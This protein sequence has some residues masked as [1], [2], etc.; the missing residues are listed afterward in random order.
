MGNLQSIC[1]AKLERGSAGAMRVVV[2]DP[3]P[4]IR[5]ILHETIGEWPEFLLVDESRTWKECKALLDIYLS[6]LLIV[7]TGTA[8]PNISL[9]T[10]DALFPVW[11]GLRP[12]GF[13]GAGDCAFDFG[14]HDCRFLV[15]FY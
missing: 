10:E 11:V 8:T 3:D 14:E 12:R 6:E 7:R 15:D 4:E 1:M 9:T 5:R 2:L 13:S